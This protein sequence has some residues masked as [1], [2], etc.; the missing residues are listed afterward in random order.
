MDFALNDD[1]RMLL[2]TARAFL[3]K[4]IDLTK[5]LQNTKST[6]A[7][8]GY[9]ENW[10]KVTDLG[11]PG[12]IIPE[13]FGGSGLTALDLV[14]VAQEIGRVI[15]PIPFLGTL[16]GTWTL[17]KA[18]S[19]TQKAAY[20][21]KIA[22]KG[23]TMALAVC[24]ANGNDEGPRSD[25]KAAKA[26]SS[27]RLNGSKSFVVDAATADTLV[28]AAEHE[29]RRGLFLVDPKADGVRIEILPWR[30]VTREVCHVTFSNAQAELLSEDDSTIWPWV[31]D[32]LLLLLAADS[33]G[34]LD[35]VLQMSVEHAKERV[36][37]GKPIGA[38]QSIKH[39]L[40][41]T[42]ARSEATKV[43]VMYA[44]WALAEDN[45]KGPISAAMAKS[46]ATDGYR[47]ATAQNIQVF[48]AIAITWQ[49]KN[50]LYF[51]RARSNGELFGSSSSHR[52]RVLALAGHELSGN[53]D[54]VRLH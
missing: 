20:L 22:G 25:T 46:Y 33:A 44:G 14:M 51:K 27:Y 24:D 15:A 6:V 41:N 45:E 21:P 53:A 1:H 36:A 11:W 18:G 39:G 54:S 50:H 43:A 38:F 8:T 35:K 5:V 37:F 9:R 49:M 10:K 31:R 52:R 40:A 30:D 47:A 12:L 17:L 48:G 26:G 42:F 3:E 7:D 32:R 2:D 29:G 34:G 16:A 19:P 28:V 23:A 4:E 13:D